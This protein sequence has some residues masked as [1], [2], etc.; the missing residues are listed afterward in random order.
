MQ[1]FNAVFK[2]YKEEVGKRFGF[3]DYKK[4]RPE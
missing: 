2:G 3:P 1:N 4:V